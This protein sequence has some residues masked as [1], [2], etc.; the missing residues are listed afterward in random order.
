MGF[1]S[2]L[3][4]LNFLWLILSTRCDCPMFRLNNEFIWRLLASLLLAIYMALFSDNLSSRTVRDFWTSGLL[5]PQISWSSILSLLSFG[6][7]ILN[8]NDNVIDWLTLILSYTL[9]GV[10]MDRWFVRGSKCSMNLSR[11]FAGSFLSSSASKAQPF[12]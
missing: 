10:S 12:D 7:D 4:G 11:I 6:Y 1:D 5:D 2:V 8:L 3:S 9:K